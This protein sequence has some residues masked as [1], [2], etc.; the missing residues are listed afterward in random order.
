MVRTTHT[1]R[2]LP[3]CV[4]NDGSERDACGQPAAVECLRP[5]RGE[6]ASQKQADVGGLGAEP[7]GEGLT[8]WLRR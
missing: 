2:V 1:Q 7:R 4:E 3:A 8:E 6:L 5:A